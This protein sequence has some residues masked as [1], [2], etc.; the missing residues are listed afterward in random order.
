[1]KRLVA[2]VCG[3]LIVL[4]GSAAAEETTAADVVWAKQ[5]VTAVIAA[6]ATNERELP[7]VRD[8]MARLRA[9]IEEGRIRLRYFC[10]V[11]EERNL[12]VQVSKAANGH[13]LLVFIVAKLRSSSRHRSWQQFA[14]HLALALV[15]E[16]IHL[17]HEENGTFAATAEW[18]FTAAQEEAATWGKTI[19]EV[20]RPWQ[21]RG[22]VPD[23]WLRLLSTA[24]EGERDEY[25][26]R[27]WFERFLQYSARR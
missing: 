9:L 26:S 22:R 15:H 20:V 12:V 13:H 7:A 21:K 24:L 17:E 27:G 18:N 10:G 11:P 14:D 6:Y 1:M 2:V 5:T 3:A 16:M 25:D 8:R 23:E 4:C 19:L